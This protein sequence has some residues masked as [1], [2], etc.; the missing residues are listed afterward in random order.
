VPT[1]E[2]ALKAK[3]EQMAAQF[4]ATQYGFF[5]GAAPVEGKGL[6]ALEE[7]EGMGSGA[8]GTLGEGGPGEAPQAGSIP[9]RP[10]CARTAASDAV[11]GPCQPPAALVLCKP[12]CCVCES[13]HTALH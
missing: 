9:P 4:D 6:A 13:E 11:L 12:G 8:S 5:G 2:A 1:D 3:M 10:R 7:L